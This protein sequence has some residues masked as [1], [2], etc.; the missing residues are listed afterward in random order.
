[1]EKKMMTLL[2]TGAMMLSS[3]ADYEKYTAAVQERDTAVADSQATSYAL[4]YDSW[5]KAMVSAGKTDNTALLVALAISKPEP[6]V[7]KTQTIAA[8]ATGPEWL[9]GVGTVVGIGFA[10]ASGYRMVDGLADAAS[11]VKN[12]TNINSGGGDISESGNI[13]T[14]SQQITSSG[15]GNVTMGDPGDSSSSEQ[16]TIEEEETSSSS[17]QVTTYPNDEWFAEGCSM[18]SHENGD[19]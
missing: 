6:M 19:C 17:G 7:V 10:G 4:Q 13:D 12:Y 11:A 9:K 2:L 3:C 14:S 16:A 5:S 1:M 8:P 15:E 18:E